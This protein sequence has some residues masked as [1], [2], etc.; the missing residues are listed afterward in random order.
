MSNPYN[1]IESF[2][3]V[4]YAALQ[5]FIVASANGVSRRIFH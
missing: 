5:V 3:T 4:Y 2:D 1:N